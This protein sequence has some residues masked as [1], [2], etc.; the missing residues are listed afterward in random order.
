VIKPPA[1]GP[2]SRGCLL[3][4]APSTA[5]APSLPRGSAPAP[6]PAAHAAG[7][8]RPPRPGQRRA[9]AANPSW[10]GRPRA[11]N[12]APPAGRPAPPS[13]RPGLSQRPSGCSAT[14]CGHRRCGRFRPA[15]PLRA[16][17]KA[18]PAAI[19][20]FS[21]GTGPQHGRRTVRRG[22]MPQGIAA[23]PGVS[24]RSLMP[25]Q[26]P[27]QRNPLPAPPR[28]PEGGIGQCP[29]RRS[30][31]K[32][33]RP[34]SP[35]TAWIRTPQARSRAR[36][37]NGDDSGPKLEAL[38]SKSPAKQAS[39]G[40]HHR[41]NDD[42]LTTETRRFSPVGK[43]GLDSFM[44]AWPSGP[45][46]HPCGHP[47]VK[48]VA[49]IRKRKKG[50]PTRPAQRGRRGHWKRAPHASQGA[51]GPRLL[52]RA[53]GQTSR[54]RNWPTASVWR[55]RDHQVTVLQRDHRH[56][57]QKTLDLSTIGNGLD[58]FGVAASWKTTSRRPPRKTVEMIGKSDK[59]DLIRRPPVVT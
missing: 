37:R 9:V 44:P 16:V 56:G 25:L 10:I 42:A 41:E 38:R 49:P 52:I 30:S 17:G 29:H 34:G 4:P 55:V 3:S 15:V 47:G 6:R 32:Q 18:D 12:E 8:D 26:T 36:G 31:A 43:G 11:V 58:E 21:R 19:A 48:Q 1:P 39:E 24:R 28:R 7:L 46:P 54:C 57:H 50:K 59:L 14:V 35:Q 13:A 23:K 51:P 2:P 22:G 27:G 40:P 20:A 5:P 53:R 45:A 33:Q